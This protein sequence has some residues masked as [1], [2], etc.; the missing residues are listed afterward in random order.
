MARERTLP[1][2]IGPTENALRALLLQALATTPIRS[3]SEWVILNAASSTDADWRMSVADALKVDDTEI[4]AVLE[5][6]RLLGL[7]DDDGLTPAGRAQLTD[8]RTRVAAT[9]SLLIEGIDADQ[10]EQVRT[11]LDLLRSRAEE[12]LAR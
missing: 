2:V 6:L 11:V 5:R 4:D 10:Q 9:T 7:L 1:T 3:Y 8:A 12:M